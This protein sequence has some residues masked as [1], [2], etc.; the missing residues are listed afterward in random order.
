MPLPKDPP[1]PPPPPPHTPP[2]PPITIMITN[3]KAYES[4]LC[5]ELFTLGDIGHF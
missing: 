5:S 3:V 1:P 2:P 4:E